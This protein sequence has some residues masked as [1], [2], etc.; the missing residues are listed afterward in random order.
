[1]GNYNVKVVD[2]EINGYGEDYYFSNEE[3]RNKHI[4]TGATYNL[5]TDKNYKF[6]GCTLRINPKKIESDI[7]YIRRLKR[8]IFKSLG[9]FIGK[10]YKNNKSLLNG[11]YLNETSLS[12]FDKSILTIHYQR[13]Y[14]SPINLKKFNQ[15]IEVAKNH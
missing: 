11:N 5:I 12:D 14:N 15:L 4:L 13:I 2:Y 6:Y 3:K 1:M 9:N 8:L 7:D 10:N